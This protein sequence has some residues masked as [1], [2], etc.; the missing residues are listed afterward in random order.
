MMILML[1][2]I[3]GGGVWMRII[4]ITDLNVMYGD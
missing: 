4:F 3:S 2:E 1:L